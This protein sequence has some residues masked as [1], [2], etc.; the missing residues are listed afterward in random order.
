MNC[1]WAIVGLA[2]GWMFAP[3]FLLLGL[4][5]YRVFVPLKPFPEVPYFDPGPSPPPLPP[6]DDEFSRQMA[7]AR[8]MR[9]RQKR[10]LA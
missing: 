8:L 7:Q 9:R 1:V 3:A 2:V 6:T 4:L 10:G 5:I